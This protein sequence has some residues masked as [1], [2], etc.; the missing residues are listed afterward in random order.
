MSKIKGNY[1]NIVLSIFY[2]LIFLPMA[3][4]MYN[5]V[6]ACDDF[7]F[8]LKSISNNLFLNAV[9]YSVF[10]WFDHSG[11]WLLFI[12]QKLINPL[13][14][15]VHLGRIYGIWMIVL[16]LVTFVIM[17]YSLKII[18]GKLLDLKGEYLK[19][20]LFLTIAVL[21]TTYYYVEVYNWYIGGTAYA[22]PFV[23][24]LLTFAYLIRYEETLEK[25][26]YIGTILAGLLPATNEI[27]DLPIGIIYLY[28]VFYVFEIGFKDKKKLINRMIPLLVFIIGGMTCVFA[29]G[30]FARQGVYDNEP[31]VIKAI[32]QTIIDLLVRLKDL[33]H[34][35]FAI[36]LFVCLVILGIKAGTTESKNKFL[37]TV[38]MTALVSFGALFPYVYGHAATTTFVEVRML[39][40]SD[41]L[42][43]IG[44]CCGCVRFG[45][46]IATRFNFVFS[47]KS[48]AITMIVVCAITT[49]GLWHNSAYSKIIQFDIINKRDLIEESYAYWD[50]VL[51]EIENS[52]DTNVV[53][54]REKEPD[55]SPYFLYSG[56][57]E[58]DVYDLPLDSVFQI[59][60]IM[61][62]VYYQKES[63]RYVI[64]E[65]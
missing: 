30:N 4:S 2:I 13:N 55:W 53:I 31:S 20:T 24:M 14:A 32:P 56:I 3:F 21:F 39:Y 12:L 45:R 8:G 1:L 34:H 37:V 38:L 18:L 65:K 48:L 54:T 47:K 50:G 22:V 44:M 17:Y 9:G 27:F 6:P 49:A 11:R 15:N 60:L 19:I 10:C 63:I 61:P 41:F 52:K 29:P 43:L 35:P 59:G 46:M 23:F 7:A 5:S 26:Y 57:V 42:M 25:K 40:F 58:E 16:F 36:F 64:G 33:A 51:T 62:N 28:A